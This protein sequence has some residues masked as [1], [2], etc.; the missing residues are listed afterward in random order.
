MVAE[1][2]GMWIKTD[3]GPYV[4]PSVLSEITTALSRE[5]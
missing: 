1:Q 3:E 5:S 4:P 2:L